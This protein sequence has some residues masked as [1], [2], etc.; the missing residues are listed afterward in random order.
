M[1]KKILFSLIVQKRKQSRKGF[2]KC[3]ANN[4]TLTRRETYLTLAFLTSSAN[5]GTIFCPKNFLKYLYLYET[6]GFGAWLAS[7][8]LREVSDF[9]VAETF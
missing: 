4:L 5:S 6:L 7:E 3:V 1:Q 8:R 2:G 9:I